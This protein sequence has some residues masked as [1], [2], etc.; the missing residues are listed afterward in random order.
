MCALSVVSCGKFLVAGSAAA[1]EPTRSSPIPLTPA[2]CQGCLHCQ[3]DSTP[4]W[5]ALEGLVVKV[6]RVALVGREPE[7]VE[8]VAVDVLRLLQA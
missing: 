4:T 8:E 3:V 2:A 6:A 5:V 7:A 1:A